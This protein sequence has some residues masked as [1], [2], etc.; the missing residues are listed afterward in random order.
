MMLQYDDVLRY[1]LGDFGTYQKFCFFML[2]L[3]SLTPVMQSFAP[4]YIQAYTDH[5]CL[6][7]AVENITQQLCNDSLTAECEELVKNL[8][9]PRESMEDLCG[10]TLGFSQCE[11]FDVGLD[12]LLHPSAPSLYTNKTTSCDHGWVYDTSQFKSTV[13]QQFDLVCDR[14]YLDALSTSVY[15]SGNLIGGV[16]YGV[17]M[18]KFGRMPGLMLAF[19]FMIIF[20]VIQAFAVNY[21]MFVVIRFLLSVASYSVY[22]AGF[23]IATEYIGPSKRTIAGMVYPMFYS[24]GYMLLTL[25]AY[26]IREWCILQLVITVPNVLFLT[27]WWIIPESP[28]WLLSVGRDE[29]A[30][31]VIRKCAKINKVEVPAHLFDGTWIP[32]LNEQSKENI[33][34]EERYS[35]LDL[36]RLPNMR[37]KSLIMFY[38]WTINN[39]VYFGISYNTSALAGDDYINAFLSALVEI[40]AY[41]IGIWMMDFR[42]LGRRWSLCITMVLSGI[43]CIC[44]AL[45]PACGPFAWI[46]ITSAM[47]GKF[48]ITSSYG[49]IYVYALELFPTPVRSIGIG[50]CSMFSCIGGIL[51]PQALLFGD[52][53]KPLPFLVFGV[54][55]IIAGILTLPLPETRREKLPETMEEGEQFGKKAPKPE[56]DVSGIG[57]GELSRL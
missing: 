12:E 6:V 4:V 19:T 13:N 51:A 54:T 29:E 33:S 14:F 8:T 40:P 23:I 26:F 48:A 39:L 38:I 1:I 49:M 18:D 41:A 10:T 24:V 53:W 42:Y 57:N 35:A 16:I 9:L 37:K 21:A 46:E 36:V 34:S 45:I 7:P 28:R 5:W 3:T 22:M 50:L 20:G 43:G 31:I 30:E 32:A 27:Y 56:E 55:S 25:Y 2:G 52:L 44:A 47:I 15:M 17:I 11:R